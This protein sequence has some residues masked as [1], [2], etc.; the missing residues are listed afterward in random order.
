MGEGRTIAR[1]VASNLGGY[2][3]AII[4][5]LVM[6]PFIVHS[7]GESAYGIWV[8]IASISGYYGLLD[9]GI[10]SA[11]LIQITQAWAAGDDALLNRR[12]STA[13][14]VLSVIATV[15]VAG[16]LFLAWQLIGLFTIPPEM[17]E[18]ARKAIVILGFGIAISV[19][20]DVFTLIPTAI[21]RV[22]VSTA[23]N[24][25]GRV[26]GAL[27]MYY[28]LSRGY[29]FVGIAVAQTVASFASWIAGVFVTVRLLPKLKVRP[30]FFDRTAVKSLVQQGLHLFLGRFS[31]VIIDWSDALVVG[32]VMHEPRAI[33]R[34]VFGNN[35]VPYFTATVTSVG[36]S[37]GAHAVAW[38][39]K[40]ESDKVR[41]LLTDGIRWV[42]AFAALGAGGLWFTGPDFLRI[43]LGT[44]VLEGGGLPSSYT[45]MMILTG[46]ALARSSMVCAREIFIARGE[47]SVLSR[48]GIAEAVANIALSVVLGHAYGLIG[49]AFG[50]LI[51]AIVIR[52]FWGPALV[53]E[54]LKV[55]VMVY[56]VRLVR[57]PAVI[58]PAMAGAAWL[59][60]R[61]MP[62]DSVVPLLILITAAGLSGVI[63]AFFA[64]L[65]G[66]ERAKIIEKAQNAI[67]RS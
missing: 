26:I 6:A 38:Q 65:D 31:G 34:Y 21:Q 33:S 44:S 61:A 57:G 66:G 7:L 46:A 8:L 51:P 42:G 11:L 49:V 22:D 53:L 41:S 36:T 13:M 50:S 28:A 35:L 59:V 45:I 3:A 9:F 29:G 58:L 48:L 23:L 24:V 64:A 14:G 17:L 67:G 16:T 5:S 1:N 43:W 19:P 20:F 10:R 56:V 27:G 15:A 47:A 25:G 12:V 18:S 40:G 54:R 55:P 37:L 62:I 32:I 52:L 2:V 60:K 39:T 4:V 63:A 30:S